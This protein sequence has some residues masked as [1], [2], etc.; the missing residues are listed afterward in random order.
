[1]KHALAALFFSSSLAALA[2]K[3]EPTTFAFEKPTPRALTVSNTV[4]I[5]T[6]VVSQFRYSDAQRRLWLGGR[7]GL[8]STTDGATFTT[9][10]AVRKF[11][12]QG[13]QG[14]SVRDAR[15]WA[16]TTRITFNNNTAVPTGDGLMFSDDNGA[17]WRTLPQPLD[18][19]GDSTER[20]GVS[21][22]RALP[23]TVAQQNV[24]YDIAIG[25]RAGTVWVASWSGGIRRTQNNGQTWQRIVLP[26]TGVQ[27]IRPTDTLRFSFEPRRGTLGDLT[28]LGF[29][30]LQASDGAVWVGTVDGICRT[31]NPD[32]LYP[33]WVKYNRTFGGLT[34]NWVIAIREQAATRARPRTIWAASWRAESNTEVFGVSYTRDN[35]ASWNTALEGERIY[36]FAFNGDSVVAVGTNG[37]FISPN[38]GET[39]FNRRNLVDQNNT[40]QFIKSGAEFIAAFVEPRVAG[41]RLWLGTEDGTAKSDDG[42]ASWTLFRADVSAAETN[43][44][45]YAYPNPFAPRIDALVRIRYKLK[46]PASVTVRIYDFGMNL[47]TTLV[48]NEA[49]QSEREEE[50]SWNGRTS[51]GAK[52]AN[53]VYFYTVEAQGQETLRGKIMVLE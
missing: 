41:A 13:V 49:R 16:S 6:N 53:G 21:T 44:N 22:L 33:S 32:S 8:V 36:D 29:A 28:F 3:T 14:L 26:P 46:S 52:V 40:R 47:V 4:G 15:I 10:T 9:V 43:A 48:Q 23:V 2:Q 25:Q 50:E 30:T 34:G 18:A 7:N 20:Y 24:I 51:A 11:N 38:G 35:G 17:T 1:M 37:V 42:G 5:G 39:W 19:P 31:D 12:E 27:R 45:T